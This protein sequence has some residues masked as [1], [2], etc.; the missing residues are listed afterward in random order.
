M[1][2]KKIGVLSA[3]VL[4]MSQ[5]C[6]QPVKQ[7]ETFAAS[8]V[9]VMTAVDSTYELIKEFEGFSCEC[10]WDNTQWTIGY[11]T[12]CPFDHPTNGSYQLQKGGHTVTEDEAKVI[13]SDLMGYF[14]NMV[15]SNCA[16][17]SMEQNQFDALL[18]AA[19]NHGNV[20]ACP[21]KY[22]LQG[23]LSA[24]EAY[25]QY[26][27]WYV[28]PGSMYETGLRNRRKKEA[29]LFFR[30][31]P[32]DSV[33]APAEDNCSA[34]YAG[35]YTTKNVTTYL[36][37]RSESAHSLSGAIIGK[38]YPNEKFTV[39][40]ANGTI[41]HVDCNGITGIV[42]MEY[43]CRFEEAPA[44]DSGD[45]DVN[46]DNVVDGRDASA[47]LEDY[48]KISSGKNSE[49]TAS[50]QRSADAN[51]DG[52][53]DAKDAS[54]ILAYYAKQSAGTTITLSQYLANFG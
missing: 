23:T 39:T 38:I 40:K 33:V 25:N 37:I 13:M 7:Q 50:Q 52:V 2:L 28:L 26:L 9:S 16:G 42:S 6:W 19:Y 41:A 11:G 22:Y 15:R 14:V 17:L 5:M 31:I 1:K 54:T 36:N 51:K 53:V 24:Q 43:I 4:L 32:M 30:D 45:G 47:V 35:T 46:N 21:L 44:V 12:K 27:N 48:S 18:S 49:L 29:D 8:D 34:D 20:N 10:R 3:A